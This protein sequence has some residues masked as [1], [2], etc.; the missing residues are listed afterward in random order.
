[1]FSCMC[2]VFFCVCVSQHSVSTRQEVMSSMQLQST[3]HRR[4]TS[5]DERSLPQPDDAAPSIDFPELSVPQNMAKHCEARVSDE[6]KGDDNHCCSPHHLE[7]ASRPCESSGIAMVAPRHRHSTAGKSPRYHSGVADQLWMESLRGDSFLRTNIGP[8]FGPL[9]RNSSSLHGNINKILDMSRTPIVQSYAHPTVEDE[10]IVFYLAHRNGAIAT[11]LIAAALIFLGN[12]VYAVITSLTMIA[13]VTYGLCIVGFLVAGAGMLW[14]NFDLKRLRREYNL[15]DPHDGG[16]RRREEA[17]CFSACCCCFCSFD[18]EDGDVNPPRGAATFRNSALHNKRCMGGGKG[19]NA[20]NLDRHG[21]PNFLPLLAR[22]DDQA[23][24]NATTTTTTQ[25]GCW[26]RP[27]RRNGKAHELFAC[28][29]IVSA[30]LYAVANIAG[31][32]CNEEET[33]RENMLRACNGVPQSDGS[34][35]FVLVATSFL[36]PVRF[37][38]FAPMYVALT[39]T[40]F[41]I[42][43]APFIVAV[44]PTAYWTAVIVMGTEVVV[45]II[46]RYLSEAKNRDA[47]EV[48]LQLHL[49]MLEA[50]QLRTL[51]EEMVSAY[52]P[53]EAARA[54]LNQKKQSVNTKATDERTYGGIFAW[55]KRAVM[56]TLALDG[57]AEW[58]SIR[59]SLDAVDLVQGIFQKF[60][61]LRES[62]SDFSTGKPSPAK[63]HS[64]GDTFTV[65]NLDC[66]DALELESAVQTILCFSVR[67]LRA[68]QELIADEYRA[69]RFQ[70]A[71][72][73]G[74][75]EK[76]RFLRSAAGP[77]QLRTMCHM[78]IGVCGGAFCSLSKTLCPV[79][80]LA[81]LAPVALSWLQGTL[82]AC[83]KPSSSSSSPSSLLHDLPGSNSSALVL[84]GMSAL[85]CS[86]ATLMY[87]HDVIPSSLSARSAPPA[88]LLL[89]A[90]E[91]VGVDSISL[92]ALD[93]DNPKADLDAPLGPG[94]VPPCYGT[95]R[96]QAVPNPLAPRHTVASVD[97]PHPSS[98]FTFG[99]GR[100]L[101]AI[102]SCCPSTP[103]GNTSVSPAALPDHS[104]VGPLAVDGNGDSFPNDGSFPNF[105][106]TEAALGSR[107][108]IDSSVGGS[109]SGFAN[110][111]PPPPQQQLQRPNAT[112]VRKQ[113]L[114]QARRRSNEGTCA[115]YRNEEKGC[116]GGGGGGKRA[117]QLSAE[118]PA[119]QQS[120]QKRSPSHLSASSTPLDNDH[121]DDDDEFG[122]VR[123]DGGGASAVNRVTMS[124]WGF[125]FF[126]F[127]DP[128]TEEHYI[129]SNRKIINTTD[130]LWS[131]GFS[132]ASFGAL[133]AVCVLDNDDRLS[134]LYRDPLPW[135]I[136]GLICC[137]ASAVT[138]YFTDHR[139]APIHRYVHVCFSV[140]TQS[141]YAVSIGVASLEYRGVSQLGDSQVMWLFVMCNW[142]A[143]R[144]N[145]THPL[146]MVLR[147]VLVCVFFMLRTVLW[148]N[149]P[150]PKMLFYYL[151]GAYVVVV[152]TMR[153]LADASKRYNFA[154]ERLVEYLAEELQTDYGRLRECLD[155]MVPEGIAGRL[156]RKAKRANARKLRRGWALNLD[157]SMR[158][159]RIYGILSNSFATS[160][161]DTAFLV[162][163]LEPRGRLLSHHHTAAAAAVFPIRPNSNSDGL[164]PP[165]N[166]PT[167]GVREAFAAAVHEMFHVLGRVQTNLLSPPGSPFHGSIECVKATACR[168][169][170]CCTGNDD[171]E[172]AA[173]GGTKNIHATASS[174]TGTS[175]SRSLLRFAIQVAKECVPHGT[176]KVRMFLHCGP[177]VGAVAGGRCV[178]FEYYG[179]AVQLALDC[180]GQQEWDSVVL[181]DRFERSCH[182]LPAARSSQ[183]LSVVPVPQ[184]EDCGNAPMRFNEFVTTANEGI[185]NFSVI[186]IPQRGMVTADGESANNDPRASA[187]S[188]PTG[189]DVATAVK[190]ERD[191]LVTCGLLRR[192]GESNLPAAVTVR[193]RGY[194]FGIPQRQL[195]LESLVQFN[196]KK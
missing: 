124:P 75:S 188:P 170:W 137:L 133:I 77:H 131:V 117:S 118:D 120:S 28:L 63:Y 24:L 48:Y 166:S 130:L 92:L 13:Y 160:V 161:H 125:F 192:T 6:N 191:P 18:R 29:G 149:V 127:D 17:S 52:M 76:E 69:E 7:E 25:E 12:V 112:P 182:F 153:V 140:L 87:F 185:N 61:S 100:V 41:G 152:F 176:M 136:L 91:G 55:N 26:R 104:D 126:K 46:V 89:D 141:M 101:V 123:P 82:R 129:I 80:P 81:L 189:E 172:A 145:A 147:D 103:V 167:S 67:A 195:S 58:S 16:R 122:L 66:R 177:V 113:Q 146:I 4:A 186:P 86:P 33:G 111:L 3:A 44:T 9:K 37:A 196:S 99:C 158:P 178:S 65:M 98:S 156:T 50:G 168:S 40:Y 132:A 45:C 23:D 78:D 139:G 138:A 116:G 20:R 175:A 74:R 57:F 68:G 108:Q 150:A 115:W 183:P 180:V 10:Y 15:G 11:C 193:I 171:D 51:T 96:P 106:S 64:F 47:Y 31:R 14:W 155:A 97:D 35:I 119:Q 128:A 142:A 27:F 93:L 2:V 1:M 90:D 94:R 72:S 121:E 169:F 174:V 49:K 5:V 79:G 154:M 163:D 143:N 184:E 30:F 102:H 194:P 42:K 62:A 60:D 53:L 114:K 8:M 56:C 43:K 22:D 19:S 157:E 135:A 71:E 95:R 84:D 179:G 165:Q 190:H 181:S 109:H 148:F 159:L 59:S 32:V 34:F 21:S 110:S 88:F 83:S 107:Q 105:S 36:M 85:V 70:T 151:Y 39:C 38:I 164:P 187:T 162:L 173:V 144:P 54:L 73:Y 134:S